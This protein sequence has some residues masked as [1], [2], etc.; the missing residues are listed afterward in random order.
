M[1]FVILGIATNS[2]FFAEKDKIIGAIVDIKNP[3]TINKER[4]HGY[5]NCTVSF[6]KEE[7]EK[8]LARGARRTCH[9]FVHE[10]FQM[11]IAKMKP[12]E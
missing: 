8:L 12:A 10:K 2:E 9:Y 4:A 6:S 11:R 3:N 1:K 7:Q 5:L